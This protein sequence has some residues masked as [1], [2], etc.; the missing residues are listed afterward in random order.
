MTLR[1]WYLCSHFTDGGTKAQR[2]EVACPGSHSE[3]L[4]QD[5]ETGGQTQALQ[6]HAVRLSQPGSQGWQHAVNGPALADGPRLRLGHLLAVRALES[7]SA[8]Q[9]WFSH[10]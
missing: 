1:A 8:A 2:G 4:E 7:H 3:V 6:T 10:L 9:F 5:L